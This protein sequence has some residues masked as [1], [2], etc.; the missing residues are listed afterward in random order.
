L[1]VKRINKPQSLGS[2]FHTD[3]HLRALLKHVRGHGELLSQVRGQLPEALGPHCQAAHIKDGQLVLFTDSPAW[4]MRLRFS[5]AQI[6]AGLRKTHPN[7][8]GLRVRVQLP[9][10]RPQRTKTRAKLSESSRR[11]LQDTAAA[12]E[13]GPLQAALKRLSRSG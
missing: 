10:H 2:F 5:A 4:V 3:S 8:R 11:H 9:Q 13:Q 6:L 12:L 1:P 7:L